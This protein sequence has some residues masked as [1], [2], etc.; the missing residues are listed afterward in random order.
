VVV[1]YCKRERV[2]A[3][4]QRRSS[5]CTPHLAVEAYMQQPPMLEAQDIQ[6]RFGRVVALRGANY[7]LVPG[8]VHAIVGDNGAGKS[9]L[10]KVISGVLQPDD[11]EIRIDDRP[12]RIRS[13]HEAR[14]LG[15]ETVYQDLA[16]APHLDAAGNL[17]LGRE[18]LMPPPLGW[19][20]F[21][22]KRSMR[23]RAEEE[24]RHLK[25]GIKSVEQP[26]LTLSGGQRQAIAV[27][28]A[29]AWGRRIVIMDEPTAALGVRESRMVLELIREIRSQGIGIIMISH[30]LPEVFEV[31]DRITVMRLGRTIAGFRRDETDM[32]TI[33][34]MMTGAKA[35]L[36]SAQA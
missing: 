3:I 10:I 26:V 36:A 16:L 15:I 35:E 12:V 24:M 32:E 25:I 6:K 30:N 23:K 13:P 8:E 31:A 28:R 21:L 33:V 1:V 7:D 14:E 9:T 18:N 22:D 11:G 17:F 27:A 19:L 29:V 34:Q 4:G 5:R 2:D 20:G